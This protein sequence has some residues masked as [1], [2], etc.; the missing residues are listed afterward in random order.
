MLSVIYQPPDASSLA[1]NDESVKPSQNEFGAATS[2]FLTRRANSAY[3]FQHKY[4]ALCCTISPMATP[5]T[6]VGQN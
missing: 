2:S 1:L 3:H 5:A 4:S 6:R